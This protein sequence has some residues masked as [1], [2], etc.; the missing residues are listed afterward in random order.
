[1]ALIVNQ[2]CAGTFYCR[3]SLAKKKKRVRNMEEGTK[4]LVFPLSHSH[5]SRVWNLS[6]KHTCIF[7]WEF[8]HRTTSEGYFRGGNP[9]GYSWRVLPRGTPLWKSQY[10]NDCSFYTGL[11]AGYV[12]HPATKK[13]LNKHIIYA[14]WIGFLILLSHPMRLFKKRQG[15]YSLWLFTF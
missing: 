10:H 3:I 14:L 5:K 4:P 12:A 15:V 1:M 9:C 11:I 7:L 2:N 8:L 6:K 13:V